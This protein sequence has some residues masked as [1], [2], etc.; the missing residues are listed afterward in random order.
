MQE[1]GSMIIVRKVYQ[2]LLEMADALLQRGC[3]KLV[4]RGTP[5]VGKSCWLLFLLWIAARHGTTT[6]LQHAGLKTRFMF[7][8]D[9]VLERDQFA[10]FKDCLRD[11][12]VWYLVDGRGAPNSHHGAHLCC[13][14]KEHYSTYRKANKRVA[15]RCMP[16]WT[17]DKLLAAR[18]HIYPHLPEA[19]VTGMFGKW[20][21][22]AR[23]C[24]WWA[25]EDEY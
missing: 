18:R 21:G 2:Q 22:E 11:A 13:S 23:Y 16:A 12:H 15:V 6:V 8:P 5:G 4:V 7:S 3:T 20:G 19:L 10:G 25:L 14:R 9:G 1:N 17:L 24:L